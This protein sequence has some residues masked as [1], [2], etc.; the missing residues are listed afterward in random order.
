MDLFVVRLISYGL[1]IIVLSPVIPVVLLTASSLAGEPVDSRGVLYVSAGLITTFLFLVIHIFKWRVDRL[2]EGTLLRDELVGRSQLR[3]LAQRISSISNESD[4]HDEVILSVSEALDTSGAAIVLRGEL[5]SVYSVKAAIGFADDFKDQFRLKHDDVFISMMEKSRK[6]A[7]TEELEFQAEGDLAMRAE[8]LGAEYDI[9]AA[10]PVHADTIFF[11]ALLLRPRARHRL[12]S[13]PDLSL[14][15]A[16][17]LQ[18][19]LNLRSRQL[20]RRAG[21][22]EKLISLGTLAAGLAHELRN[23]LVSIQTNAALLQ[24]GSLDAESQKEFSEIMY[25]DVARIVGIVENISSFATRDTVKF[26]SLNV[27]EVIDSAYEISHSRFKESGV[28]LKFENREAPYIHG[29]YNQLLQVFINL[30]QNGVEALENTKNGVIEVSIS[31]KVRDV[32]NPSI[33]IT[34]TDNGPGVD[35]EIIGR[36]FDPLFSTKSTGTRVGGGGMGL[37]LSIVKRVIDCHH[38]TI[39][40]ENL[41]GR[42]G[43]QFL[44]SIPLEALN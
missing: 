6:A 41:P 20:E 29:N 44:I 42:A 16:I 7:L 1:F 11:G 17:G 43:A 13:S 3:S 28:T 24:E 25:R 35:P 39:R 8:R 9:A 22:T 36:L 15:D 38:G 4:M 37:G 21:Q 2:L 30:F 5:D 40:L 33:E 12:F 31:S 27:S 26:T 19:G 32:I 23:P 10:I 34:V 18:I 14:L